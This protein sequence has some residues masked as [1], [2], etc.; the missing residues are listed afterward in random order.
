MLEPTYPDSLSPSRATDFQNCPLLYRLRSIDR[1]PEPPSAAA[2]KGTLVHQSLEW[3]FDEPAQL[4]TLASLRDN[5]LKACSTLADSEPEAFAC[6][7]AGMTSPNSDDLLRHVSPL[8]EAYFRLEQPQFLEPYAREQELSAPLEEHFRIR[9]Y[10]D[11]IDRAPDGRIRI[12]DYKTG[13]APGERFAGKA[14]F[15]LKF[16]ALAWWKTTNEIPAQLQLIYLGSSDVLRYSPSVEDLI[17][18][19]RKILALRDAIA[20]AVI[21][22]FV[23]KTGALCSWCS[24]Q[25]LCP[26]YG[27]QPPTMPD[28]R[29]LLGAPPQRR[30]DQG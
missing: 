9:G 12:V 19:E 22:G 10:V 26:A 2:V 25:T 8:L 23:P 4:R 29:G 1:I 3:L 18:T 5:F 11:R 28:V 15:Q 14:L 7:T 21:D 27:G 16:Y 20:R 17:A 24:F 13:K 6:F 30:A